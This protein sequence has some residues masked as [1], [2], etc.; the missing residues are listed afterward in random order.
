M[1]PVWHINISASLGWVQM[2]STSSEFRIYIEDTDAGGIVYYVNYLKFMERARTEFMRSLGF[3]KTAIWDESMFV[4]HRVEVDY[5]APARLDDTI[6]VTA[7]PIEVGRVTV[8]FEQTVTRAGEL[9]CSGIVKVASVHGQ[10]MKPTRLNGE[11]YKRL[12]E[13]VK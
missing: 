12:K 13:E 10:T 2:A 9:L 4:V 5:K 3:N 1:R 7:R 11:L 8:V 6:V